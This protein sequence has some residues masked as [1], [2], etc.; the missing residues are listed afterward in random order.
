MATPRAAVRLRRLRQRFGI[1]APRVAIRT[2]VAW[3]WRGLAWIVLLAISLALAAWIYDAGRKFA[4]YDSNESTREIQSLRNYVMEL[5]AELTKL[6]GQAGS[7]ESRLQIEQAALRR[8]SDQVRELGLENAALKQDLAFFEEL[9]PSAELGDAFGLKINHLRVEP[10]GRAGEYRYRMLA[11]YNSGRQSPVK[12]AQGSLRLVVK[13]QQNGRDVMITIP[14]GKEQDTERFRFEV[15]YFHRLDGLFSV[16]RDA[17]VKSVE[18]QL[19][20][21]GV[22]RAKQS[23]TL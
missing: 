3:Y 10:G 4:G 14:A 13:M 11:I 12:I 7:G 15:K 20:Q 6:R 18:A 5:D 16:P 2:H 17:V 19:L 23:V 21:D 9:I 1:G 8:L 22:V